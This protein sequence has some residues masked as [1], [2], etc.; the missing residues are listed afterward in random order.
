MI[1]NTYVMQA[2]L[3]TV[4]DAEAG[5]LAI[6]RLEFQNSETIALIEIINK[7]KSFK[8]EMQ[9]ICKLYISM[10]LYYTSMPNKTVSTLR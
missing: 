5:I 1:T 9:V 6:Y 4:V 8:P 2:I 3:D 10:F 7:A